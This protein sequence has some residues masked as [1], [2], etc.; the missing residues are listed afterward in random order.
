LSERS[1]LRLHSASVDGFLKATG[2][3][4]IFQFSA[5]PGMW[6]LPPVSH[7]PPSYP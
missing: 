6:Y 5:F 4:R 1:P 7:E 3:S 2:F